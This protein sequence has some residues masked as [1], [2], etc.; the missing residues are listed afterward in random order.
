MHLL[1][2]TASSIHAGRAAQHHVYG[3]FQYAFC[4]ARGLL[5]DAS[6]IEDA[7]ILNADP[8][9][10]AVNK[11]LY[12]RKTFRPN[13]EQKQ[14]C[15]PRIMATALSRGLGTQDDIVLTSSFGSQNSL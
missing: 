11:N 5:A 6:S 12:G 10:A 1:K 15:H 8:S 13:N 9:N 7:F 3:S 2:S 4:C 14:I